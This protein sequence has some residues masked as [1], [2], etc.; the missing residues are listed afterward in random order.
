MTLHLATLLNWIEIA[1][2]LGG[3]ILIHECGH[4]L[5]AK[6]AGM[7]VE[8]FAIGI[9]PALR[10]WERGGTVY[11]LAPL[12]FMG[13]VRIRGMEGEPDADVMPGSFYG[14]PHGQRIV[15]MIGGAVLNLLTAAVLFCL[16]YSVWGSPDSNVDTTVAQVTAGSAAEQA[17]IAEGWRIVSLDG[18]PMTRHQDVEQAIR[19]GGGAAVTVGLVDPD[20][21]SHQITVTPRFDDALKRYLMGVTFRDDGGFTTEIAQVSADGPAAHAGLRRGD[22]VLS[23]NGRPALHPDDVML[24]IEKLTPQQEKARPG[25]FTPAPIK[26]TV[27]RAGQSLEIELTPATKKA[28]REK[29]PAPGEKIDPNADRDVESYLIG[30]GGF[31]L[32]RRFKHLGPGAAIGTGFEHSW[33]IIEGVLDNLAML[34]H[35]RGLKEVGGPVMIVKTLSEAAHNGLYELLQWAGTLSIMIGMLNLVP[36]PELDGG[37]VVFIIFDWLWTRV[38]RRRELD[39]RF[40]GWVHAVGL[41]VLLLLMAVVSIRDLRR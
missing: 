1:L 37:R 30:D 2:T 11:R 3:I 12:L 4:F 16:L 33:H 7:D 10:T 35:G 19:N 6:W 26:L 34:I 14:R 25:S 31:L 40:E 24:P 38:G 27:E 15:V 8:E 5:T 36:L 39:R 23:V 32:A 13:Y 17:G 28:L 20:G 9:G 18:R 21:A 29:P 22:R 41:M